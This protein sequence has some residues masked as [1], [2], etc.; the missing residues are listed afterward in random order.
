MNS[1]EIDRLGFRKKQAMAYKYL[2]EGRNI[3]L[4]GNAGTGKSY[5]IQ[6]F[7][8]WCDSKDKNVVITAPT[9]I[10][11][12][13]IQGVTLHR[14]FKVPIGPLVEEIKSISGILRVADVVII[15]EISMCRI[16][17]FEYV[18]KQIIYANMLRRRSGEPDI[19]FIV[20]GDFLQLP[21]VM[22]K[23]DREVLEQYYKKPLGYG[24]A[25]QSKL[26]KAC[27]FIGINLDETVRQSDE[28]FANNLTQARLGDQRCLDYFYKNSCKTEM[29]KAIMLCGTNKAVKEKND[30]EL[31]L[32]PTDEIIYNSLIIGEVKESD[33]AVDDEIHL[34]LGARVMLTINDPEGKYSSGSM[35]TILKLKDSSI[36][37]VLDSKKTVEIERYTWSIKGYALEEVTDEDG[38]TTTK[39]E[40]KEIGS[41]SQLP[42]KLAYAITIHKSQGQTYDEV[43][44]DPYCWDCGQ[45]Y[46]AL[47]RCKSIDKIHF[48][49]MINPAY[50]KASKL[51]LNFYKEFA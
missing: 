40:M 33:K 8:E 12:L 14:A 10:A 42:I 48:T 15:D 46:V 16:D 3:F 30:L 25:F 32:L 4:T 34:K 1:N 49:R 5:V 37:V 41:F 9:G 7:I 17:L 2:L 11:A 13:N 26:W 45:L 50:L 21:P 47:S 35:G 27:G 31:S 6:K 19:Q 18:A 44:I 29:K 20:V 43:N 23:E 28:I 51:V 39:L 22:L 38:N 24:Y 36:V